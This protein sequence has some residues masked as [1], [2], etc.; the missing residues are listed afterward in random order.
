M[1]EHSVRIHDRHQVEVKLAYKL[2]D[3]ASARSYEVSAF[4][5]L[6][7]S[8]GVTPGSYSKRDFFNDLISHIRVKTPDVLLRD[9]ASQADGPLRKLA[10]SFD[11]LARQANRRTESS[12]EYRLKM[13]C[14]ILKSALRDH[15]G[16]LAGRSTA[17]QAHLVDEFSG[18]VRSIA[19]AFRQLRTIINVPTVRR[20][21][22]SKFQFADEYVSLLVEAYTF[23]ML[24]V[25]RTQNGALFEVHRSGLLALIKEEIAYRGDNGYPSIPDANGDN[26]TLVFRKSVLK[27]WVERVLF[28]GTR[29][30]REGTVA[31][32]TLFAV[33]AGL[34]MVF[35]TSVA[36]LAQRFYG[37]LTFPLFVALVVSYML[38]DRIKELL[39][40]FFN[41]K[42]QGFFLDRRQQ[43]FGDE[44]ARERI[45]T[46]KEGF[47]FVGE[48]R[49]PAGVRRLRNRDHITEIENGWVGETVV[50]YRKRITLLPGWFERMQGDYR[51]EG[52]SDI[53]RLN[54]SGF[55]S[56]MDEPKKPLWV[57][58][59]TDYR[60][61][62]GQRVYH[63][64]LVVQCCSGSWADE[65]RF[66]LVLNKEGI[67]RV[68]P[69]GDGVPAFVDERPAVDSD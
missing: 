68:E 5:F 55:L 9:M 41:A 24:E 37:N 17:D 50:A 39:R 43:I 15:V 26:E 53:L 66:R 58:D 19:A 27:K 29:T 62:A 8:L 54:V 35:A 67:K 56:R 25:L 18:S 57:I 40:V 46:V 1:I 64:N 60:D 11:L 33:A 61:I 21:F 45:G 42:I 20:E 34:S 4:L 12:C 48:K 32:Q 28:L 44:Q 7:G 36:F 59:G 47:D 63:I 52:L 13:F 23:E 16:A 49:I 14:C 6:P 31:E 22:F 38:K 2:D 65:R 30:K 3:F 51:V 69:V 10:D